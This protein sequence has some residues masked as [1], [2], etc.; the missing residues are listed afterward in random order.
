[1]NHHHEAQPEFAYGR[2]RRQRRLLVVG[3]AVGTI[4]PLLI[5]PLF[6]TAI[7]APGLL[8]LLFYVGLAGILL[9]GA[10][11]FT[12]FAAMRSINRTPLRD[13]DERQ[14]LV[15]GRA[16]RAAFHIIVISTT[17]AYLLNLFG[18]LRWI[19]FSTGGIWSL[20]MVHSLPLA[21]MAW[22]EPD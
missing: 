20:M 21:I 2:P 15:S 4:W 3:M 8:T 7:K 12:L 16:Y 13:L 14:A 10:S 5:E 1:M 19:N 22:T 18:W 9:A 6:K 11:Y 17:L